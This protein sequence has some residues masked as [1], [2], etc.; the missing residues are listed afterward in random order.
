MA[1]I[2]LSIDT[3]HEGVDWVNTLLATL[4][5]I[6]KA[7]I[8]DYA[9]PNQPPRSH[10]DTTQPDWAFTICW[11]LAYDTDTNARVE[12]LAN[13][14]SPLHRTGLTTA[15]QMT[16][17]GEKAAQ[18]EQFSPLVHRIGQ[19]FVVLAPDMSYQPQSLDELPLRLGT[20]CAFGSG[21]HPATALSLQLLE[22]YVLPSMTVLDFGSGSGILSVAMAK[23]GASVLAIDND[24]IAVDATQKA[25]HWNGLEQKVTVMQGSLGQGSDLGH[26]MGGF[27]VGTVPAINAVGTFD[28]IAANILARVH[29]ALAPDFQRALRRMNEHTGFLVTAGFTTEYEHEVNMALTEIGFEAIACLRHNEWVALAHRLA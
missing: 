28:L 18:T 24:P 26:W 11:Y 12:E 6:G 5:S 14:L 22:Q 7:H 2:E 15:L 13:L 27:H 16:V 17:V 4:P 25:V 1:W 3:L 9:Q 10:Q 20:T 29:I 23:L 21:L 19:R 8:T